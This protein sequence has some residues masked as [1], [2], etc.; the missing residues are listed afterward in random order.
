MDGSRR[1]N[2]HLQIKQ[3]GPPFQAVSAV[4]VQ[5]AIMGWLLCSFQQISDLLMKDVLSPSPQP[6]APSAPLL[7]PLH[8]QPLSSAPCTLSPWLWAE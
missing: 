4:T 1:G 3:S 6:L 8:P 7:S 2:Y 5:G